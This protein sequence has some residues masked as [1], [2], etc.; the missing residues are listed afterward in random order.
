[1]KLKKP[2]LLFLLSSMIIGPVHA[3]FNKKYS[4]AEKPADV[5]LESGTFI[6]RTNRDY[7]YITIKDGNLNPG[8]IAFIEGYIN[9][10]QF[11][12]WMFIPAGAGFYRIKSPSGVYL[13]QKRAIA[14]TIEPEANEDS[15]LWRVIENADGFY[16]LVTK[17]GKYL[18]YNMPV[19]KNKQAIA[20]TNTADNSVKQQWHLIK[21]TEDGRKTTPFNPEVHG[22]KFANTFQGVDASYR[23][24]GLCGGMVYSSMDYFKAGKAIPPQTYRP[25]NRTPLQSFIYGRQNDAAMVNQLDK[26]TEL[27]V[28]PF[29]WRDGEFYEWG[30][31][32]SGGGRIE[33]LRALIDARNPAPLGL[34]E[35][36]T[37]DYAGK[38]YG[39][40]QV[41]AISYA[42][43]RYKGDLGKN[44]QDFKIL[45]YDPNHPLRTMTLVP[46]IS[47]ACYFYVE[48]GDTWRTYFVD[49]KYTP[50][51]PPDVST[52]A[53]NEPDGSIRNIYATFRT[54]GDDLRGGNDNLNVTVNYRDGGFQ[55]FTNVN[56]G[57]RWVDNYEET[58]H[59]VLNRPVRKED[60]VS[61][62][63]T[64][65]FGGGIGG[66]NWNL[67][68]FHVGNGGN[69]EIVC[70]NCQRDARFPLVRFTGDRKTFTI[71]VR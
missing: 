30:L 19:L 55:T 49:R 24:G 48:T 32:G 54:G 3:E 29:G 47:R 21:M 68:W 11:Q 52:F 14:L 60:I 63:L 33:E 58:V 1:M 36:G 65:T 28:N 53:A 16:T 34:Y 18:T 26:W 56:R 35:G 5:Y 39:D 59:L 61:F 25:A 31:K 41:L 57:A 4:P 50:K 40:H 22:F 17:T 10:L 62:T 71:P 64:T 42:M 13:S 23:Y 45:I 8:N 46:D 66:D 51:A 70:A 69:I 2:I 20:F 37:T 67:D 7:R 9:N 12:G 15:Q 43:G 27:R 44:K 38:K 6:L